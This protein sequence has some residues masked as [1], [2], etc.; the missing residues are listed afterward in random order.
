MLMLA[1]ALAWQICKIKAWFRKDPEIAIY[2]A[3]TGNKLHLDPNCR[4]LKRSRL[5]ME[6]CSNCSLDLKIALAEKIADKNGKTK[7]D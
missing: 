1:I 5:K 7:D 6:F 2:M 4:Y 3:D